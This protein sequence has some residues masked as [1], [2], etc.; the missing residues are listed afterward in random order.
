MDADDPCRLT[1][2]SIL[3]ALQVLAV[4]KAPDVVQS[5]REMD[6]LTLQLFNEKS[7]LNKDAP[8]LSSDT[9]EIVDFFNALLAADLIL[10]VH[11][12]A[13]ERMS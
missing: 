6:A 7:P 13:A 4:L 5:N 12:S 11:L 1:E 9:N 2:E 10:G 8:Q 3:F